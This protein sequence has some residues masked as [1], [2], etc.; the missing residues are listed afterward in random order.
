MA[1]LAGGWLWG[2]IPGCSSAPIKVEC[3]E[4]QARLDYGDLSGDQKRFARQ[5]L[6]DCRGRVQAAEARDSAFIEGTER[7]FTPSETDG[8]PS[9]TDGTPSDSGGTGAGS[10]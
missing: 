4:L 9:E 1:A 2:C 7:R 5:E 3:Q 8:M 10:K 6:D